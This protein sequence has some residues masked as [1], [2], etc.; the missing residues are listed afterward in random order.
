MTPAHILEAPPPVF[1]LTRRVS[2][3][4]PTGGASKHKRAFWTGLNVMIF[5]FF[6]HHVLHI[7]QDIC[8]RKELKN[9]NYCTFKEVRG[10][11]KGYKFS[12][13]NQRWGDV[14]KRSYCCYLDDDSPM[15]IFVIN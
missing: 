5:F 8:T 4:W 7:F 14:M 6:N 1:T 13:N 12:E 15:I 2:I 3:K 11:F 9:N 10:S